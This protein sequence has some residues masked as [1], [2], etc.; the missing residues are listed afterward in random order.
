MSKTA[1]VVQLKYVKPIPSKNEKYP[2]P[3]HIWKLQMDNGDVGEAWYGSKDTP[4]TM[5][6]SVTYDF[7]PSQQEGWSAKIKVVREK[8][9][10]GFGGGSKGWSPEK[11]N[12]VF[13]QG[14][15]KSIIEAGI[16]S[17]KWPEALAKALMV[18]D[19]AADARLKKEA[20]KAPQAQPL[21]AQVDSIRLGEFADQPF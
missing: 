12:Q 14:Y 1:Q 6:Q 8:K 5:G 11:E 21:Q 20:A 7:E 2:E 4:P 19:A 3:S 9:A 17:D 13:I 18:H 15:L 10:G 16:A